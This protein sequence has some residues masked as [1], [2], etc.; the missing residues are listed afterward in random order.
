M[1][2]SAF[3]F[4]HTTSRDGSRLVSMAIPSTPE[5]ES[6]I[7]SL[8]LRQPTDPSSWESLEVLPPAQHSD[9]KQLWST[10][11]TMAWALRTGSLTLA[12]LVR[13]LTK[14]LAVRGHPSNERIARVFLAIFAHA[15]RAGTAVETLNEVLD[16]IA[17]VDC[18][19]YLVAPF[20]PIPGTVPFTL[21]RFH[22]GA[23]DYDRI[24]Y[25]CKKVDCDFFERYPSTFAN[26]FAI[27][28]EHISVPVLN[29]NE[30]LTRVAG[31]GGS[32]PPMILDAYFNALTE[33]MRALFEQE[34][35]AA[36]E[37]LVTAGAPFLDVSD[38][39]MILNFTFVALYYTNRTAR[40]W[41]YFCPLSF[42]LQTPASGTGNAP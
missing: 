3:G 15:P 42:D 11:P 2:S 37:V 26:C 30:L 39:K 9:G 40:A 32:I 24:R 19:Q 8:T 17:P 21:G 10:N 22:V 31:R 25:W 1:A 7:S 6:L 33:E 12:G 38:S 28:G 14:D 35:L 36:Q 34:F 27:E 29:A 18:T 5:F 13:R 41:G 20:P 23:L 4:I 16:M